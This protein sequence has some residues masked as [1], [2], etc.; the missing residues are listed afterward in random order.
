MILIFDFYILQFIC[1]LYVTGTSYPDALNL[2]LYRFW[3]S[4]HFPVLPRT[5][6][7]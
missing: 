1:I 2:C 5:P 6:F 3:F 7:V 4:I